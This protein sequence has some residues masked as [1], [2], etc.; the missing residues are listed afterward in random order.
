MTRV[1]KQPFQEMWENVAL[2]NGMEML[3][4]IAE[5]SGLILPSVR[6]EY[7]FCYQIIHVEDNGILVKKCLLIFKD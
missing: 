3:C 6:F 4:Y 7:L 2:Y 1:V 5:V